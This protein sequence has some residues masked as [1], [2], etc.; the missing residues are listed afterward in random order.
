MP[1]RLSWKYSQLQ[2]NEIATVWHTRNPFKIFNLSD[3]L[4]KIRTN[5]IK[6]ETFSES[7]QKHLSFQALKSSINDFYKYVPMPKPYR[8]HKLL[9]YLLPPGHLQFDIK[10]IG[11]CDNKFNKNIYCVDMVDERSGMVYGRASLSYPK[12]FIISVVKDAY[13]YFSNFF[14]I[15]RVRTDHA[16]TF[17]RTEALHAGE[18]NDLL[19]SMNTNH[20]YSIWGQP[21]TNGKIESIHEQ[22]DKE[23]LTFINKC[24][25]VEQAIELVNGWYSAYNTDRTKG[26]KLWNHERQKWDSYRMTP[27]QSLNF[28]YALY[29]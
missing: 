11:A 7:L 21:E 23:L 28:N 14:T 12:E 20:Q 3:Y 24:E 4:F 22:I 16:L 9:K 29:T 10:V 17:K 26:Y 18:F 8:K 13:E 1:K 19:V 5:Q 27:I 2:R 6:L 15:T 25:T